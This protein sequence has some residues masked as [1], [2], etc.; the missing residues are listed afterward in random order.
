[1]F[2]ASHLSDESERFG[3]PAPSHVVPVVDRLSSGRH[4]ETL[5]RLDPYK[6]LVTYDHHEEVIKI[7]RYAPHSDLALRL[8]VPNTGS[9]VEPSSKFGAL[10]GEAVDLIAFAHNNK[11]V[12]RAVRKTA[13]R[14]CTWP[15]AFSR[16]PS[17]V[18]SIRSS[19]TSAVV[20]LPTTTTRSLPSGDSRK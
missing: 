4:K 3:L 13:A 12:G 19:L 7:A 17:R 1:L 11:L 15:R 10:P 14:R 5:Q 2:G 6:P 9:M 8:R 18:A 20:F 16:R